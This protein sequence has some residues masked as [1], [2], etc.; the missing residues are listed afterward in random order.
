M[1]FGVELYD[2]L[3]KMD[4]YAL[5]D[6][7]L[8]RWAKK[9]LY[10]FGNFTSFIR[11]GESR[12]KAIIKGF[13]SI[14]Y[15]CCWNECDYKLLGKNYPVK[16]A[17]KNFYY[18]SLY[19]P[20][21]APPTALTGRRKVMVNHS[22]SSDGN[23]LTILEKLKNIDHAKDIEILT[24]LSYGSAETIRE[25]KRFCLD[26]FGERS[27]LI[28]E[29]LPR[30]KY[31]E[32]LKAYP[33]AI[34]GHRRQEA[35]GNIFRLLAAGVKVFL[36]EDNNMLK[37]LRS[38]DFIVFSFEKDLNSLA[39]LEPLHFDQVLENNN[40]YNSIFSEDEEEKTM[41]ELFTSNQ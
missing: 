35:A 41:G 30:D 40:I 33:I 24:P 6:A 26:C 21:P 29:F 31:F 4:R 32:V 5:F 39:D 19:R 14:D 13:G 27:Q 28:T 9:I 15:F 7:E 25:V 2:L 8:N 18:Y 23:H 12:T 37:W 3:Y 10:Y 1:F 38:R 20:V 34:F 16:C 22:G 11:F 17:F 36:R